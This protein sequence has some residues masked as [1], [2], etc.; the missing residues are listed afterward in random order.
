MIKTYNPLTV[1]AGHYGSGKTTLAV[2]YAL[3]LKSQGKEVVIADLDIVNPYFRTKDSAVKLE[4]A[5]IR[6]ISSEFAN[7]NV[8]VPAIPAE[9]SALFDNPGVYSIIDLGG[10]DRGAH[11]LGRYGSRIRRIG[12]YDMFLVINMYRPL[13]G[14]ADSTI[15]IMREIEE[16]AKLR[17]TGVINNSNLKHETTVDDIMNSAAYTKRISETTGLPV[18]YTSARQNLADGL[19]KSI[20]NV[21]ALYLEEYQWQRNQL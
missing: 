9:A 20:D 18:I 21:Y 1:F 8:D 15:G 4:N 3:D 5:G 11:V 17:F 13:S 7:S 12:G 16:S 14:D 6:L 10:D 19:R 2:N